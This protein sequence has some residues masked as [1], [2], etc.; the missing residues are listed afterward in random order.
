MELLKYITVESGD[1]LNDALTKIH[2][3]IGHSN[4][5]ITE[6]PNRLAGNSKILRLSVKGSLERFVKV[7]GPGFIIDEL[8]GHFK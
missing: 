8:Y 1:D 6:P 7:D 2:I 5:Y 4:L 3:V